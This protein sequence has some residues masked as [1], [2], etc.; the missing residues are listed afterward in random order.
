MSTNR[1]WLFLSVFL[2]TL[3]MGCRQE[4]PDLRI[5]NKT[6][7][8]VGSPEVIKEVNQSTQVVTGE[9]ATTADDKAGDVA[10]AEDKTGAVAVKTKY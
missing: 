4:N 7:D 3:L 9:P 8:A 6:G 2:V 1:L 10:T 5:E